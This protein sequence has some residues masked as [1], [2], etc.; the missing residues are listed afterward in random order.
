MPLGCVGDSCK[1]WRGL[2]DGFGRHD[3]VCDEEPPDERADLKNTQE[4][5]GAAKRLLLGFVAEN[6]G[7][8]Q[9]AER[10]A[11]G[12]DAQQA[13]FGH[14]AFV[15]EGAFFVEPH[16]EKGSRAEQAD[17]V[18]NDIVIHGGAVANLRALG[19]RIFSDVQC[20][21]VGV[22]AGRSLLCCAMSNEVEK[23][24]KLAVLIDA[25]NVSHRIVERLFE[26]IAT[27]GEASVR[28]IYGDFSG[29]RLKSWAE[30]LAQHAIIPNQNFANTVGKNASD[31]A[32]VID[33][34]DLLHMGRFDGFCLVS[35]DSDFTRLAMRIREQGVDVFGFGEQKTPESF[36][37]SCKRFIYTENFVNSGPEVA[38]SVAVDAAMPLPEKP[39]EKLPPSA[40]TRLIKTAMA[41]VDDGTGWSA[42]GPVGSRIIALQ[43]DFDPR[44]YGCSKLVTLIERIGSFEIRRENQAVSIKLKGKK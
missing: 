38:A 30:L 36:R 32:L 31:I 41:Q 34:M 1:G 26:E 42:L 44:T 9:A 18:E 43:S 14:S 27:I 12:H 33:A 5:H 15:S 22:T 10:A 40:A 28:R 24:P 11:H 3:G 17:P 23:S 20:R 4:D 35:S 25:D 21:M 13:A 6:I 8:E 39:A 7:C 16:A 37:V 29:T 2:G 19:N